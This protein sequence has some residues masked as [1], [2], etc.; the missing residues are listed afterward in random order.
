MSTTTEN[1]WALQAKRW[2]YVK[3]PLRPGPQDVARVE[4]Y[5]SKLN[6]NQKPFSGVLLGVTPELANAN[7]DMSLTAVELEQAM[8]N[9]VW[10]GDTANRKA[11]IGNWFNLLE[12]TNNTTV[13]WVM[14]DGCFNAVEFSNYDKF[15][16]SI[17]DV[18]KE[19]GLLSIRLFQRPVVTENVSSI[20]NNP[21]E[22][23][24]FHIFKWHL[25]MAIQG[26]D[27]HKG[28]KLSDVW[29]AFNQR[30]PNKQSLADIT[31]WSIDEISTIDN[32]QEVQSRYSF[33]TIS[34]MANVAGNYDINLIE[35]NYGSYEL[36]ER[37]PQLLFQK[38]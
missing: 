9:L 16:S 18:L 3:Q 15:M 6:S 31:G 19:D 33:P 28:V 29:N 26:D 17:A 36:S 13:D 24:N 11:V 38:Q 1:L 27:A 2:Q 8:I 37:C 20:L 14:G 7:L 25:V 12:A 21:A 30:Y 22:C 10:T 5:F 34:E 32:Y 35:T 23:G 4:Q